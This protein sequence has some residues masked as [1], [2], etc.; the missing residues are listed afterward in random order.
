L[1][2]TDGSTRVA[3]DLPSSLM[4]GLENA[5]VSAAAA[6]LDEKLVALAKAITGVSTEDS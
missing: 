2:D 3:Y 6:K 1:S 5:D 4:S